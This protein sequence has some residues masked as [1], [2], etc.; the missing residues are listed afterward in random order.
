M[1]PDL[2]DGEYGVALLPM[3]ENQASSP[4]EGEISCFFS[5]CG[6]NLGFPLE[7]QWG[8]SLNTRVFS[9]TS[10]LLPNFQRNFGVLL[11]SWQGSRAMFLETLWS[12]IKEVTSPFVFDVEHRIILQAVQVNR[13]SSHGFSRGAAGTWGFLLSY[14]G[15]SSSKLVFVQR[16]QDSCRVARDTLGFSSRLGRAIGMPLNVRQETQGP[17]A[18]AT[19]IL[20]SY[21]FSRGVR[22]R[23]LLKH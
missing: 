2:F 3:Q 23:L 21:R 17:F 6:G 9:V 11:E 1:P 16:H 8:C 15:D 12:S 5:S 19:G 22:H 13:A 10:G 20:G 7:L 4:D 18:V 14:N